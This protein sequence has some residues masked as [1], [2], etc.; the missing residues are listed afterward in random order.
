LARFDRI[1]LG[2]YG[3][4]GGYVELFGDWIPYRDSPEVN[5]DAMLRLAN[6]Y[7][8]TEIVLSELAQAGQFSIEERF[9]TETDPDGTPWIE[10]KD[11]YLQWKVQHGGPPDQ[12]LVLSGD[13][14]TAATDPSAWRIEG[15]TLYFDPS[16]LPSYAPYHQTG[17]KGGKLPARPYIGFDE[18]TIAGFDTIFSE[19]VDQGISNWDEYP[20]WFTAGKPFTR[21]SGV[22]QARDILG[23]FGPKI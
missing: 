11:T 2:V 12:I 4:P 13:L 19:W 15:D 18:E 23:R 20:P 22:T 8:N 16:G 17:A 21:P 14:R 5:A 1:D 7:E 3:V 6:Y 10:L 9:E